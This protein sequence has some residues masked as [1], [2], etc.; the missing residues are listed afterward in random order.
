[1]RLPNGYG[2]VSK[3]SG[4]RRNPYQVRVTI[5]RDEI[6]G[7]YI[8]KPL[9]YY[10]TKKEALEALAAY[11]ADP[12]DLTAEKLTFAQVYER[13]SEFYF[14]KITASAQG[15]HRA[16][17]KH[18]SPLYNLPMSEIRLFHL[19]SL[20][21]TCSLTYP[22]RQRVKNLCQ[23]LFAYAIRYEV[24][25]EN[26]VQYVDLGTKEEKEAIHKP[27]TPEELDTLWNHLDI[28]WVDTILILCY[29]GMRFGELLKMRTEDVHLEERYMIGGSKTAAGK[30]RIIPIHHR[31]LPLIER[32]YSS[33]S[34]TLLPKMD[35]T[36]YNRRFK[37]A[38]ASVGLPPHLTHDC[39]HTFASRMDA[40][41]ANIRATKAIMGHTGGDVTDKVYI[42]K[43][44][45]ELLKSIELLG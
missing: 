42:H 30:N 24:V 40:A 45:D 2:S 28:P 26:P 11:N 39:R 43:A 33:D 38:I 20:I 5:G 10:H 3:L 8:R 32:Y 27:F 7:E 13:W 22:S 21:D 18:C 34:E 12:Y 31:I 17:Y 35:E 29:T 16:A 9:G 41:G 36:T 14:P 44:L 6:T 1:M 19:Q 23:M 25:K 4:K 15:T 37:K